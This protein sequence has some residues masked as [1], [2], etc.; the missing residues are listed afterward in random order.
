MRPAWRSHRPLACRRICRTSIK[1][2]SPQ[3]LQAGAPVP[4]VAQG[5]ERQRLHQVKRPFEL[6]P[7][8]TTYLARP[9]GRR[10]HF[11][12]SSLPPSRMSAERL[13]RI[14]QEKSPAR[15][16][17]CWPCTAVR[18]RRQGGSTW[19]R[20]PTRCSW[21]NSVPD[22]HMPSGWP[23][24]WR[25]AWLRSISIRSRSFTCLADPSSIPAGGGEPGLDR[26][27]GSRGRAVAAVGGRVPRPPQGPCG[28][29]S[30]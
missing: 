10:P 11:P 19:P 14:W 27:A 22:T 4:C 7:T 3:G 26:P 12:R 13:Q 29:G 17:I 30:D 20:Q 23:C 18:R 15:V 28:R 21:R 9:P 8:R 25:T 24:A 2:L 1:D 6:N 16:R 5:R